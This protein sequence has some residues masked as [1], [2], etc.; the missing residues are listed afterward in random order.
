MGILQLRLASKKNEKNGLIENTIPDE[1]TLARRMEIGRP[2]KD[3]S[4]RLN[5]ERCIEDL[6]QLA[7]YLF[8]FSGGQ[9]NTACCN[10]AE[11]T[12]KACLD[13]C[14]GKLPPEGMNSRAFKGAE[15]FGLGRSRQSRGLDM[16]YESLEN[17]S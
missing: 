4:V 6:R 11:V 1:S 14:T 10:A 16:D 2:I 13:L 3:M 12:T 15:H 17:R 8:C 9:D 7:D 5:S